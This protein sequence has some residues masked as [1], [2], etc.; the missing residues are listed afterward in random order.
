MSYGPDRQAAMDTMVTALDSYV[1]KGNVVALCWTCLMPRC[2]WRGTGRGQDFRMGWLG[3]GGG[4]PYQVL[5]E[6]DVI[7]SASAHFQTEVLI[8]VDVILTESAC[9]QTEVLIEVDVILSASA[10]FQT[11]VLIEVDVILSAS[12]CFQTEVLIEV[13]V[14][15][16]DF[17]HQGQVLIELIVTQILPV[18]ND[19]CWLKLVSYSQILPFSVTRVDWSWCHTLRSCRFQWQGLIE[20]GV[21]LSDSAIVSDK[22]Y[23]SRHHTLRSCHCQW[24]VLIEVSIILSDLAIVSDKC[25]LR[26]ASYSQILPLSVT[27][28]IEVSITLSGSACFQWQVLIETGVILSDSQSACFQWWRLIEVG[29]VLSDAARWQCLMRSQ[30]PTLAVKYDTSRT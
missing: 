29:V 14:T 22:G 27:R 24:Q 10:C 7:L 11:E 1:I 19:K 13:D 18:S 5:I 9:F 4:Q 12:A 23:W 6:V 26:S 8:E 25:W 2:L 3:G 21:I 20:V 16:L 30:A 28:V 15:L 17:A